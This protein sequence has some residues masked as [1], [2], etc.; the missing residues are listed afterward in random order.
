MKMNE[1]IIYK[2]FI[3][4]KHKN[5]QFQIFIK[6]NKRFYSSQKQI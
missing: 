5:L 1:L 6:K 4:V 3:E 2:L